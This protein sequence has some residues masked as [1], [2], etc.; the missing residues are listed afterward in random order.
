MYKLLNKDIIKL[1]LATGHV[2]LDTLK[3][4]LQAEQK[5]VDDAFFRL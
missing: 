2:R 4:Y 1:Q 5:E 3:H